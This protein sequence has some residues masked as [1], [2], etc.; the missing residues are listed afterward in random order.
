MRFGDCVLNNIFFTCSLL[1][2]MEIHY[3]GAFGQPFDHLG[4]PL[5]PLFRYGHQRSSLIVV[6]TLRPFLLCAILANFCL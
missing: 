4:F 5:S 3:Y 1:V 2:T 6:L